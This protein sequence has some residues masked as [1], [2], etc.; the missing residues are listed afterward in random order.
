MASCT[1]DDFHRKGDHYR[2][3]K[4]AWRVLLRVAANDWSGEG[5]RGLQC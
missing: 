4:R 3:L 1:L 5:G 2:D